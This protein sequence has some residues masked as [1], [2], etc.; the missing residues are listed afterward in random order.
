MTIIILTSIG[1]IASIFSA[2]FAWC[3]AKKA[4]ASATYANNIKTEI[5]NKTQLKELSEIEFKTTEI[6]KRVGKIGPAYNE[7]SIKGIKYQLISEEIQNFSTFINKNQNTLKDKKYINAFCDELLK[8]CNKLSEAK[9][10]REIK[11]FGEKIYNLI[12]SFSPRI[13]PLIENKIY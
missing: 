6:L 13:K 7:K 8:S 3:Q 9:E 5:I 11:E 10:F 1:S 4:K 2:L 12:H